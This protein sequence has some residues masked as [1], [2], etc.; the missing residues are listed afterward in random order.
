MR[1]LAILWLAALCASAQKLNIRLVEGQG[2]INVIGSKTGRDFAILVEE[3]GGTPRKEIPVTF[4]APESGPSGFF[5]G[6]KGSVTVKTNERGYAVVSGFRA[7]KVP[8]KYTIAVKAEVPGGVEL[9]SAIP[10]T[11]AVPGGDDDEG[12]KESGLAAPKKAIGKVRS[13]VGGWLGW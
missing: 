13:T 7:N 3:R 1:L 2:A 10:Q 12:A 5:K 8:G 9:R 6:D 11:N 4:S